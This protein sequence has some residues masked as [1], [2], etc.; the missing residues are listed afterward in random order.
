TASEVLAKGV[1]LCIGK[2]HLLV[3]L[4]RANGIA[5]GLVYQ[6]LRFDA[7]DGPY[8]THC[9]VALRLDDGGWYR[10]DARGN[11]PGID[12]EFT[13]GRENLAFK[14]EHVGERLWP[15]V[16]AAPWPEVVAAMRVTRDLDHYK[17]APIDVGPPEH[18]TS[19]V[20]G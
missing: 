8:C 17:Q 7:L 19:V 10:C 16:W 20:I 4:L 12:C 2:S 6:R 5:A 3:A 11:R 1:S 9:L 13:P 18:A 14:V 15:E